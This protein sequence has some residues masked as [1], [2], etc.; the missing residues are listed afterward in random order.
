VI[1]EHFAENSEE[2]ELAEYGMLFWGNMNYNY[3]EAAMGYV[4]N[5][6]FEGGLSTVRTW[7]QPYLITYMESHDEERLLYKNVNFGKVS[8]SYS[9]KDTTTALKRVELDAAFF[10][11]Q[12]GPKMIWQ[13]GELGYDYSINYCADGTI[14]NNCRVDP[15]PI[16]WDYYNDPRR[17]HVYELFQNLIRLRFHPWYRAAFMS[18]RV[19]HNFSGVFKWLKLTTDTSNLVVVGNFDVVPATGSVTFQ[20]SGT[21][22]DYLNN[23][24]YTPTGAAQ[25]INLQPGEFHVYVNRNVNNVTATAIPNVPWNGQDLTVRA[26]PNPVRGALQVDVAL[27]QNGAVQLQLLDVA[28]RK[29]AALPQVYKLKGMHRFTFNPSQLPVTAGLYFVQLQTKNRTKITPI[30]IP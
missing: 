13:F 12:P 3:S 7:S 11:T 17:R 25:D 28:G 27:S 30:L 6:N 23:T 16:R 29:I 14:N 22:Y 18:N 10:F 2:K 20:G 4:E 24:I 21:W 26:Y 8:G 9:T 19:E 1:L 15:K 5:S